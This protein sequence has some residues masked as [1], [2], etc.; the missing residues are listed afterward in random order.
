MKNLEQSVE[1]YLEKDYGQY[2]HKEL[3][4]VVILEFIKE[5]QIAIYQTLTNDERLDLIGM[6][7]IS[8]GEI[9]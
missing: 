3:L 5:N 6:T 4:K 2:M 1:N 7:D 8:N 9:K